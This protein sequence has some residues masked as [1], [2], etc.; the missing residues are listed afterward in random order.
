MTYGFSGLSSAF[1]GISGR[2]VLKLRAKGVFPCENGKF[3]LKECVSAYIGY[4][5]TVHGAAG[6]T[7]QV[8]RARLL[9]AQARVAELELAKLEGSLCKTED[10]RRSAF[11][12]GRRLRDA[13]LIVPDRVDA[14]LAAENDRQRVNSTLRQ[15]LSQALHEFSESPSPS[16]AEPRGAVGPGK[17]C[18][19]C[20]IHDEQTPKKRRSS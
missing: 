16:P 3:P 14:I 7:V 18:G 9:R 1:L 17:G 10:V 20:S 2:W 8:E 11:T 12:E 4:L 5:R 19:G 6:P 13:I 15:E